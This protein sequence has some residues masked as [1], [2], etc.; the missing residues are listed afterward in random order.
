MK[1]VSV[2][3]IV[4]WT[5]DIPGMTN[6]RNLLTLYNAAIETHCKHG[7]IVEIGTWCGK[8]A[9]VLARAAQALGTQ[10]ICYEPNPPLEYW[11]GYV[12]EQEFQSIIKPV[13]D[14]GGPFAQ[15]EKHL[16][17]FPNVTLIRSGYTGREEAIRFAFVDGDHTY[18]G[19]CGDVLQLQNSFLP[20]A[21]IVC[22]D[23]MVG[24][25]PDV[26][27]AALQILGC[28]GR[29]RNLKAINNKMIQADFIG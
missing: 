7:V 26:T 5:R 20:N 6:T 18:A 28:G 2:E 19:F 21:R 27:L 1:N 8:S 13:Y 12:T 24:K 25:Y 16:R 11:Q 17:Q 10:L 15:A 3:T 23:V 22:D 4:E 9:S 29:Y 14:I